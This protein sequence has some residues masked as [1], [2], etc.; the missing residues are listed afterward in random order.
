[1]CSMSVIS[2]V[3]SAIMPA[4]IKATDLRAGA[5][6]ILAGLVATGKTE[7]FEI[8]HIDRGFVSIEKK[9]QSIGANIKRVSQ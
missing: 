8:Y 1:M 9:L 2:V 3:P 4:R 5:A 7:V 6:L